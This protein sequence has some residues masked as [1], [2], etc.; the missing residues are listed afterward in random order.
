MPNV[1]MNDDYP[2]DEFDRLRPDAFSEFDQYMDAL[3][4]RLHENLPDE[5]AEE[6]TRNQIDD[7]VYGA[8]ARD[9]PYDEGKDRHPARMTQA[10]S[11]AELKLIELSKEWFEKLHGTRYH[12][13]ILLSGRTYDKYV[14]DLIIEG[15]KGSIYEGGV[16]FAEIKIPKLFPE[17]CPIISFS[18]FIM[19]PEFQDN[20]MF[21]YKNLRRYWKYDMDL[22]S[23]VDFVY[24]N[25]VN[26]MTKT[27]FFPFCHAAIHFGHREATSHQLPFG[28]L[29]TCDLFEEATALHC[30]RDLVDYADLTANVLH[31]PL[32]AVEENCDKFN[33]YMMCT[34][35]VRPDC[36]QSRAPNI[37]KMYE[38]ICE[39]KFAAIMK[40]EKKCLLEVENDKQVKECF[41]NKTNTL[42][43]ETPD[44]ASMP[45][46]TYEC[47]V[48]QA[49]VDCLFERES[50]TCKDA[51]KI[52]ISFL[53]MLAKR[54]ADSE[55]N[56]MMNA[57][58]S[59]PK[60]KPLEECDDRGNCKCRLA[61]YYYDA[62]QKKCLD[63][64]EC[65]SLSSAC[66][67]V[68]TN[69]P[70]SYECSCDE[71]F[72]RLASDNKTC[73]RIDKTPFWLFFAHGQS[74]WN[75]ST[76]GKSFQLQRA[77]LQKTA[78]IDVD[79]KERRLYYADIGANVIERMNIDGTFPQAVQRFDVDGLEGIAVDWIGRN[80]YSLRKT[81]ILVQS[82]DGRF[83]T[84]VYRNVMTLPRSIALH[85]SKGLMFVTDWSSNAFIAVAAMDGS[86]FRK[87]VTDR[88]TWPNAIAID[89][90]AEKI[91][92]ADAFLD[93][94]ETANMDGTG[95]RTVVSDAGSVPH[96][97]GLAV[98]DDFI[99]WTDWTYRGILRA[100]KQNGE[101][102]TV[103]A[104]TA[105]LPY[106]LKVFHKTL[107]P[108]QPSPCELM[109]CGQLCLLGENGAS[110]CSCGEGFEL[111]EDNKT[112]S[113]NCSDM[114]IECGGS[115]PKCISK[116]YLCDGLAQCS[117][118]A[119]EMNCPPRICLPGQFQCHDNKK[120]LPPGGLCDEVPDC[121]DGSDEIYCPEPNKDCA[122][123]NDPNG[124]FVINDSKNGTT[125]S[126]KCNPGYSSNCY[127]FSC[128]QGAWNPEPEPC[129]PTRARRQTQECFAIGVPLGSNI[130]YSAPASNTMTY[131]QGTQATISCAPG[132]QI[133][134]PT[135]STCNNGIWDPLT[136]GPC[137]LAQASS[138]GCLAHIPPIGGE[139]IYSTDHQIGVYPAGTTATA[140][141]TNGANIEGVSTASCTNGAWSP[142]MFGTCAVFTTPPIN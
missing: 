59:R 66:S 23:V 85:P 51:V 94:I 9:E 22:I 119:D 136:L 141:C 52:E 18:T 134:G 133:Q 36:R 46:T 125:G 3:P 86:R 35:G 21:A 95:R 99:Y 120:C 89:I 70:G 7:Y 11:P 60:E 96:I 26:V 113:S 27:L 4:D 104:Q 6:G 117:N 103:L 63:V 81:D 101:N 142:P 33:H 31:P 53:S 8:V 87:I 98:A 76:D 124:E 137:I 127:T 28:A 5:I 75:I 57:T 56:L 107:Q 83:R 67:Q 77:G 12:D 58:R 79:V 93:T 126:L 92:W 45:T 140:R 1:Q 39:E 78:M 13:C 43:D 38:T 123:L 71:R 90:F 106:S 130:S 62:A 102:I 121:A 32:S 30:L 100:N 29:N 68:C 132:H 135:T 48:I 15:P 64:N 82:L 115:D 37:E 91:Y 54:N 19:H 50:E 80:L 55:C 47:T 129:T 17:E 61:G 42:R 44:T 138:T 109:G 139:L 74:V 105:L 116:L 25:L 73:D 2:M 34:S 20:A 10:V 97:F 65:D 112:C 49:Y 128:L 72:Y 88:I 24:D 40:D 131:S 114:Q 122:P 110:K 108:D 69:L 14:W 118:Q 84:S 16:F 111:Q 41:V